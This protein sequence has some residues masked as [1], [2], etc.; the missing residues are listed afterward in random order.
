LKGKRRLTENIIGLAKDV[1]KDLM[2]IQ[3]FPEFVQT[4]EKTC[5]INVK[6]AM[7]SLEHH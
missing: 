4:V 7:K 3:N 2:P 5:I 1:T 6:N